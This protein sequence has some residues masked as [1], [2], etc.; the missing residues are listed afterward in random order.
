MNRRTMT[1]YLMQD[2]GVHLSLSEELRSATRHKHHALNTQIISR[3]PLCVPPHADSPFTYAKGMIVFGQIYFAFEEVL[4]MQLASPDQQMRE[5][6]D[7]IHLP[8]LPRTSWL[9]NDIAMLKSRMLRSEPDEFESLAEE[10]KVFYR[11][12][13]GSL[14]E[15]PHVLLAYTWTMYLALFN[16][17][18]WIRGQ[19]ISAGCDFWRGEAFPL[20]F[21]DFG[22]VGQDNFDVD[23]LKDLFKVRFG[24]ATSNLMDDERRDVVEETNK[25]FDLCLEMVELLD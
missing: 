16:G 3:L 12:I 2:E 5:R 20:S 23:Q 22:R 10:S 9:R 19:L 8:Q 1:Q 11:R 25:L 13:H 6:Y 15:R 24:E 7:R 14:A 17:G 18:R 4:A 21:W